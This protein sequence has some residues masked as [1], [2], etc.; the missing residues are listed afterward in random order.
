MTK[1][2]INRTRV[3]VPYILYALGLLPLLPD[4][5]PPVPAPEPALPPLSSLVSLTCWHLRSSHLPTALPVALLPGSR[6][7]APAP[8]PAYPVPLSPWPPV[9]APR[10]IHL[11]GSAMLCWNG[12]TSISWVKTDFV[13]TVKRSRLI[14]RAIKWSRSNFRLLRS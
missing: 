8:E 12:C 13:T 14:F 6:L 3:A 4:S 7:P 9:P 2:A 10:C 1:N 5:H 11:Q